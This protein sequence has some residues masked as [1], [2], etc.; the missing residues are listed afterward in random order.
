[1][2]LLDFQRKGVN[3]TLPPGDENK[4][5]YFSISKNFTR[6]TNG[7]NKYKT[8]PRIKNFKHPYDGYYET[9]SIIVKENKKKW[10]SLPFV[11]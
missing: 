5:K 6:I 4:M 10:A 3:D 8:R 7:T 9:Y 1:M 2:I 11:D